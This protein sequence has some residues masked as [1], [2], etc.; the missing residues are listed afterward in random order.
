LPLVALSG[1]I[2]AVSMPV[3]LAPHNEP[4]IIVLWYV[5]KDTIPLV[6]AIDDEV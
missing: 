4:Q 1:R 2:L 5:P 6:I 3:A